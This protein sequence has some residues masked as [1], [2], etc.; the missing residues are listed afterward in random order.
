MAGDI[1]IAELAIVL[2]AGASMSTRGVERQ[3]RKALGRVVHHYGSRVVIGEVAAAA[4]EGMRAVVP[5]GAVGA[6]AAAIPSDVTADLDPVGLLGLAAFDL[7]QSAEYTR[8]KATRPLQGEPWDTMAASA[9]DV[10]HADLNVEAAASESATPTSSRLT[11]SVSVAVVMVSG[12]TPDLQFSDDERTKVVAEVQNGLSWLGS[13][14]ANPITWKYSIATVYIHTPADPNAPD[15]EAVWRVPAMENLGYPGTYAGVLE[16][17]QYIQ[18][19][20]YD[21]D[22]G[23]CAFFTKYPVGH[24]AYAYLGGPYLVM[25]YA[26][27][28]WGPNNIDRVFAHETCHIFNAPDEYAASGC[29]CGGA[30]GYYGVPNGNCANCAPGGGVP[31]IMQAASFA[32]C[33][34]TPWH[35]GLDSLPLMDSPP[36]RLYGFSE[37]R[38]DVFWK[39]AFNGSLGDTWWTGTEWKSSVLS[40]SRMYS[41]PAPLYGFS[42]GRIDVFWVEQFGSLADTWWNGTE[43][44]VAGL[45][46]GPLDSPP[47][48]LSGF[49]EGRMDVFW[50][51]DDGYLWDT[52]WTGTAWADAKISQWQISSTP[53][54][55]TG[56]ADLRMDVFWTD[57]IG[58]LWDSWWVA[59][60]GWQDSKIS[61]G[62][63]GSPP[64]PLSGFA[65]G[66]TDVFWMNTGG[67][68]WDSWW[69]SG[70]GWADVK[71]SDGKLDSPPA[72]LTGFAAG[73]MD[74]FWKD[75]DGALWDTWWNGTEWED[76]KLSDGPLN[77]IPAT[78]YGFA[79]GRMDVF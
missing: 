6:S 19:Y 13:V 61:A 39:G 75:S 55:L 2:K 4:E 71:L 37:G 78:L 40:F 57:S 36:A 32:V 70:S 77:S 34:Y 33:N 50:K 8:A 14:P 53:A 56:A 73:R 28:G 46:A 30:W 22:W 42:E 20:V 49:T 47:A 16:Y 45:S 7:R 38:L 67:S 21:T 17:V 64:A 72:P 9:P 24:F 62:P 23:Y 51:G 25:Q 54:P 15:L 65:E 1:D 11:G 60:P 63:M 59:D 18:N 68:L 26:I 3:V 44:A 43:W 41:D 48:P 10:V 79:E 58:A 69:T 76:M 74:V 31:C 12:P 35:L 29:D 27:D 66:R 5:E 52:Y